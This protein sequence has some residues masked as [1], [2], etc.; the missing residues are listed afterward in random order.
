MQQKIGEPVWYFIFGPP[1]KSSFCAQYALE[2]G[3]QH[4]AHPTE[5]A[6]RALHDHYRKPLIVEGSPELFYAVE[7]WK[8]ELTAVF[9][10]GAQLSPAE[11][12]IRRDYEIIGRA[13]FVP[14]SNYA[15]FRKELN[16]QLVIVYGASEVLITSLLKSYFNHIGY[17]HVSGHFT[18]NELLALPKGNNYMFTD[19]VPEI[20]EMEILHTYYHVKIVHLRHNRT[21]LAG[22]EAFFDKEA[23]LTPLLQGKHYYHSVSGYIN[24]IIE[25]V[26]RSLLPEMLYVNVHEAAERQ[27]VKK[28]A[29]ERNALL[30]NVFEI[31]EVLRRKPNKAKA[32]YDKNLLLTEVIFLNFTRSEIIITD[33]PFAPQEFAQ[34]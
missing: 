18:A 15:S 24:D 34:F 29:E 5:A 1:V 4:L 22:R 11:D 16:P 3:Y 25:Q 27:A 20:S 14:E 33:Y 21:E 28:Y 13:E 17:F 12:A 7:K 23:Q 8:N 26:G 10:P 2:H 6:L 31:Q 32:D 9:V 19:F 30:L